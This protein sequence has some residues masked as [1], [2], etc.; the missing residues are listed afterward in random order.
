MVLVRNLF[1][2]FPSLRLSSLAV[3]FTLTAAALASAGTVTISSPASNSSVTAPIRVVAS[4][5]SSRSITAI[6]IYLDGNGVYTIKSTSKIDTKISASVG[7]HRITVKAWDSS[8]AS[9][10]SSV[11]AKVTSTT[12]GSTGGSTTVPS[13]AAVFSRIEQM[14]GWGS[15]TSCAGGG[16]QAIYKMSQN[17]SSPSLDGNSAKFFLGGSTSF[18]HGLWWRRMS[19]NSTATHF[20]FDMYYYMNNPS[21]SQGLEFAANQSKDNKWYKFSTQCTWGKNEWRVW[22]SKNGGWVGTGIAC[23]RPP[24][25]S[26]Q[27]VTFEYAR[28]NGKA[29]FVSITVNGKKSYPNKSFYPQAKSGNG[30]VGIH[31]QLNGNR[32][33]TDYNVW[34]D[35]MTLKYW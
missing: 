1:L 27:H 12:S 20:V 21:A 14:S 6:K 13:T 33:Q 2:H 9:F 4:A 18:S 11:Y 3:V 30:S 25:Y 35:K 8:G 16:E 34:A 5:S 29:V 23:N 19:S 22:D 32:A 24:A 15:C 17:Q 7:S 31:F 26:W 28:S 10:S